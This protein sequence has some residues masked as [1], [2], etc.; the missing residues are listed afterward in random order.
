MSPPP[1]R[2][3]RSWRGRQ[4]DAD[5]VAVNRAASAMA[6]PPESG[7]E[8]PGPPDLWAAERRGPRRATARLPGCRARHVGCDVASGGIRS[9]PPARNRRAGR[10][11]EPCPAQAQSPATSPGRI[12]EF[13]GPGAHH[14]DQLVHPR[15][16]PAVRHRQW[17]GRPDGAKAGVDIIESQG[18]RRGAPGRGLQSTPPS[19]RPTRHRRHRVPAPRGHPGGRRSAARLNSPAIADDSSSPRASRVGTSRL[20]SAS[21]LRLRL[22]R[23]RLFPSEPI[24]RASAQP[25]R[26]IRADTGCARP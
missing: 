3:P 12:V 4:N 15:P 14:P 8:G 22:G 19:P 17:F 7:A 2:E 13:A 1:N 20:T 25:D 24:Y 23:V 9:V 21:R 18:H 26:P 11:G 10:G 5:R 16:I 6:S